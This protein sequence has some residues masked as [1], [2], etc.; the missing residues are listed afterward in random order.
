MPSFGF[1]PDEAR[2]LAQWFSVRDDQNWPFPADD[3]DLDVDLLAE[4]AQIF[5]TYQCNQCHP[6]G[7]QLPSN[8]DKL[9]WGPDLSISAERLK[10]EWIHEW[11]VDPQVVSPGTKMPNFFGENAE[12]EYEVYVEDYE[13]QS[14]ALRHFL[15]FMSEWHPP[16]EVSQN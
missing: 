16:Q 9:N 6:A 15:K 8:P 2:A 7:D 14:Q 3:S 10:G 1:T 5:E 4:G 12:G 11:L 13:E